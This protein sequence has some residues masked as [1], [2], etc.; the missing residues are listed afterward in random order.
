MPHSIVRSFFEVIGIFFGAIIVAWVLQAYL[1]KPFQI[2]S[3]SMVPTIDIGDRVLV[4]RLAY[5]YGEVK[6]GDVIVFKA[7][8]EP[9]VDYVKRVIAV[10]GDQVEVTPGGTVYLNGEPQIENFTNPNF[11]SVQ[12]FAEQTVPAGNVFVMGDNR[13][14]SKDSRFWTSPWLP[15]DEIIGKAFFTYWPPGRM[16]MLN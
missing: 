3:E 2:P 13:G 1:V 11:I 10:G 7:P 4:N 15:V 12:P 9:D 6:R 14:D 8:M 5:R 16:G